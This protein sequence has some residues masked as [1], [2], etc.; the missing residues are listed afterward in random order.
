MEER[1][2][3][4]KN[5]VDFHMIIW[6]F[7]IFSIVGLVLEM[8]YGYITM[9]QWENRQG[10]VFGPFCP[11]YGVGAVIF[12]L[13]LTKYQDSCTKLFVSGASLGTIVE[14][15]LSY[16]LE[17][18]YGNRFWDYSYTKYH[19][20]GR[21]SLIYSVFWG[22]LAILLIKFFKPWIDNLIQKIKQN[23]RKKL[24]IALYIFFI[25]NALLTVWAVNG[26]TQRAYSIYNQKDE[27]IEQNIWQEINE[28]IFN[29]TR[30]KKIFPNLRIY[31]E[32][33]NAIFIRDIL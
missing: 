5:I 17:A 8:L 13:I 4:Q 29:N 12:I 14:Y 26:Y 33:G 20:N 1:E 11:I 22:V 6:Y 25:V 7:L 31:D 9:G 27:K 18:I 19:L 30:M 21:V 23:W 15:I 10:L 3:K 2:I 32:E 24:E 16:V 28:K